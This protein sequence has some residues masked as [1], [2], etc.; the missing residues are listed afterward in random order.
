MP[1]ALTESDVKS[2]PITGLQ[3]M[4]TKRMNYKIAESHYKKAE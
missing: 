2:K 1:D 4:M 3:K